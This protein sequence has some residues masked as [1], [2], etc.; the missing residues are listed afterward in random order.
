M[1]KE[2]KVHCIDIEI[3]AKAFYYDPLGDGPLLP[4]TTELESLQNL[5]DL[6]E[7]VLENISLKSGQTIIEHKT[8]SEV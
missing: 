7:L 5:F 1:S 4:M 2:S 3:K 8:E 6:Q